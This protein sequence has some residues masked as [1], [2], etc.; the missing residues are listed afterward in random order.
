MASSVAFFVD[1]SFLSIGHPFLDLS[2]TFFDFNASSLK[3]LEINA[4]LALSYRRPLIQEEA[5][6]KA[7]A[8]E[9]DA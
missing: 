7:T 3:C 1:H 4:C 6:D 9:G 2:R 8:R 5:I